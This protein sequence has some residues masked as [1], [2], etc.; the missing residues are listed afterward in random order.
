VSI[1]Y[2]ILGLLQ[3]KD[4]HGYRLKKLI[5]RDFG[6]MWTVNYGQIY[7]ALKEMLDQGLVTMSIEAKADSPDRKLYAITPDGQRVFQEWL[8]AEP[9]RR[10]LIRDPFL[11]RFTFFGAGDS[12]RV[13]RAIDDK[14]DYYEEQLGIRKK[15]IA[16]RQRR[17][18]Y[19]RLAT[20]L[21]IDFNEMMLAWLRR[22]RAEIEQAG[23]EAAAPRS[24]GKGIEHGI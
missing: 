17:D 5:E 12:D 14:I 18:R 10:L 7:P 23:D 13:L 4:M 2:A 3:F 24:T 19:V 11:L 9:E 1:K 20:E 22:A 21:G 8:A 16:E 6:F 15:F